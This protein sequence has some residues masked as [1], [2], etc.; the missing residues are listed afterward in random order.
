LEFSLKKDK[1]PEF[2]L[3]ESSYDLLENKALN[4][5]P[6]PETMIPRPFVL[7][8]AVIFK[9]TISHE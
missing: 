6:R 3:Y 5:P 4:V 2:T 8:D 1:K 7:N 9:K